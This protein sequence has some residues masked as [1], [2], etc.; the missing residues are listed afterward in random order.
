MASKGSNPRS[1]TARRSNQSGDEVLRANTAS[2]SNTSSGLFQNLRRLAKSSTKSSLT[3]PSATT[4]GSQVSATSPKNGKS[5]VTS[6]HRGDKATRSPSSDTPKLLSKKSSLNQ[7]NL[8]QYVGME[9]PTILGGAPSTSSQATAASS[10]RIHSGHSASKYSYSR[11]SSTQ[12]SSTESRQLSMTDQS[13]ATSVLSQGSLHNL[14]KFITPDGQFNPEMPSDTYEVEM[15]FEE[16]MLKR[17]ILQSLPP[18]KQQELMGYDV[19]KKWLIVKQDLQNDFKRMQKAKAKLPTT[20]TGVGATTNSTDVGT[21]ANSIGN[22]NASGISGGVSPFMPQGPMSSSTIVNFPS[23]TSKLSLDGVSRLPKKKSNATMHDL[24]MYSGR[25][26]SSS[27]MASDKTNRPPSYYVKKIL[28]D[29]L[30]LEECNDLWVTLRTEQLDWVDSFLEH[31][32]HIAMANVLMNSLYRITSH[33]HSHSSSSNSSSSSDTHALLNKENAYFKCFK[34]LVML[35]QGLK[36]FTSHQIMTD[37]ITR[38][39]FSSKLSTKRM[40]TEICVLMLQKRDKKRFEAVLSSLDRNF[41]IGQNYHMTLGFKKYPKYFTAL[42]LNTQLKVIQCWRFAVEQTVDGRGKM[43]SLVGASEDYRNSGGENN[44]LEYCHWTMILVNRLCDNSD[45][46]RQ[47]VH[48]R[49]KLENAGFLRIMNKFKALNYEKLT[50]E[51]E[52]YENSKLDDFNTMLETDNNKINANVNMSDPVSLLKSLWEV[53]KGTQNEKLLTSLIQHLFLSSSRLIDSDDDDTRQ[54][55]KQLK[56]MD[57][58]ITNISVSSSDGESNMNMAIQR[59]YDSMQTD[60][61]A[62]RAILESRTLTKKLEEARARNAVLE[63]KL[64]RAGNGLVG[65]L[66]NDLKDRDRIL[67]KNQRVTQQLQSELEELK[68]RHLLEKH[69]Q[70]VEL[71]KMLTI[72]NS[73]PEL[74]GTD[75]GAEKRKNIQRVLQEGLRRANKDFTADSKKFGMTLQP[76]KRLK[77]LKS[78]MEDLENEAR[79]L[80]MINYAEYQKS[81]LE[82]PVKVVADKPKK[83]TKPLKMSRRRVSAA[84]ESKIKKLNELRDVLSAIQLE[85]NDISKF[86]VEE[87][88]NNLFIEKKMQALQRL[89]E[90]ERKY[91]GFNID[92]DMNEIMKATNEI[93]EM[94]GP[95]EAENDKNSES[96]GQTEYPTLDPNIY[97]KKLAELDALIANLTKLQNSMQERLNESEETDDSLVSS[98]TESSPAVDYEESPQTRHKSVVGSG[99]YGGSLLETLSQKYGTG[100]R[101]VSSPLATSTTVNERKFLS[102]MRTAH[103]PYL[104]ELTKR[105][106]M[107]NAAKEAAEGSSGSLSEQPEEAKLSSNIDKESGKR[108]QTPPAK[109]ASPVLNKVESTISEVDEQPKE[110]SPTPTSELEAVPSQSPQRKVSRE[111]TPVSLSSAFEDNARLLGSP[112]IPLPTPSST[113]SSFSVDRS[114]AGDLSGA[115]LPPPLPAFLSGH[116]DDVPRGETPPPLPSELFANS[117][118]RTINTPPPP[119]APPLLSSSRRRVESPVFSPAPSL[120]DRYPRP[121][122]KLKQLHWD[123]IDSTDNSI[124]SMNRAEKFADDLYEKGVLSQLERAFAAR[125]VK[126]LASRRKEDLDKITF[127]SRDISQQFGINLHMYTSLTVDELVSKILKCDRA[128]IHTPSVIDFLSKPEIIEVS[129]NLAR[130]Y[131]PYSTDWEGVK[132]VDDAKPP[133]KDPQELQRADQIY[134]Q[135]MVNLQSYWGSRMRA[136]KMITTYEREYNELLSKLRK[137]DKAVAA[138]Q[139]SE[140]LRNVFN[141]IL[142]VGNYMNDTS[143]QAQGFKLSTLQRLTF[144]KDSTNSMTFLNFVEKIIRSNYPTFNN[145]VVELEPVLDVVKISIEQLVNDCKEYSQSILNVERSIKIGNL[146]DSSKFHPEDKILIKTLPVLSEARKKAE[147][148]DDE[149]KLS[150]M[151]FHGLMQIYGEDSEDKFAKNSFFKKFA[152][153]INEYKRAQAQNMEAEEE[154]RLYE[155]RKKMVEEQQRKLQEE[156][157]RREE[158]LGNDEDE[159]DGEGD[160]RA[161]MDKLLEQLKNAGTQRKNDPSSARKR[162]IARKKMAADK[163]TSASNMS[164]EFETDEDSIIYSPEMKVKASTPLVKSGSRIS[165][166]KRTVSSSQASSNLS[167]LLEG[168]TN[169]S[170]ENGAD[171]DNEN[172]ED[173][174]KALLMELRGSAELSPRASQSMG[175]RKERLRERRRANTSNEDTSN[176]L[177]F[178]DRSNGEIVE[179]SEGQDTRDEGKPDSAVDHQAMTGQRD[180]SDTEETQRASPGEDNVSGDGDKPLPENVDEQADGYQTAETSVQAA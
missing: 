144:I 173:R 152:D 149:V 67:A 117:P 154:E 61:V 13:S 77:I 24:Y 116:L 113:S 66:E 174:A 133:E 21:I 143:K 8:S 132:S 85:S 162:A 105:M 27:T 19:K 87:H 40:A 125:E 166:M 58:L 137:I 50:E 45:D 86:N 15:L 150:M 165:S 74:D 83:K 130:N 54:L 30:T 104:Q 136:I 140:N 16:L 127:L 68:R 164:Q 26:S 156:K 106:S 94:F 18:E 46:V 172:I 75:I 34:V 5:Q 91:K 78:R 4:R 171:D 62:R 72:L 88:V 112:G 81:D 179:E 101:S 115:V 138:L 111:G 98:S 57:A 139:D 157:R 147:L 47:R 90:L 102:R 17:N 51:V 36:E 103:A 84:K 121:Q 60:E 7:Q 99:H 52:S 11:R 92:F 53:C 153:F 126:S 176:A 145:F 20:T 2:S 80:E 49:T 96:E 64:S 59:L 114:E 123:K 12:L 128:L 146:S 69:E 38:G 169:E 158:G 37:T 120:F 108:E 22:S 168:T 25:A 175:K 170:D 73:N 6:P 135:L 14:A 178:F 1:P 42:D 177:K 28:A 93:N 118:S 100:Q 160:K 122:K 31:Q 79:K 63:D 161:V 109:E 167:G 151:E 44:I 41:R 131:A 148:L 32:G 159:E 97:Q 180:T 35:R 155:Q 134:L 95:K 56:L 141:V 9:P 89:K 107:V 70:E 129:T 10:S 76:N 119:P 33:H 43:G 48:L 65:Q 29:K 142:A 3:S 82:S 71:R 163:D 110:A 124:W 23:S 55:S 39:L